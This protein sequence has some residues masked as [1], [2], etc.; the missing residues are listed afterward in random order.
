MVGIVGAAVLMMVWQ[1]RVARTA[2]VAAVAMLLVAPAIYSATVWQ[3]PVNGTFPV[4]GP[5][6]EDDVESLGIPLDQV[7]IYRQL[8]VYVRAHQPASRW[9]VLTQGATTAAPLT[10]LGGRVGALGGYGT[11]DPVLEPPALAQLVARGEIRYVALGGGY[12]TRGGNAS[13]TVVAAACTPVAPAKWRSPQNIGSPGHP[14]IV[15]P[16][17]GWNLQLY[18]C[19]GRSR[20]IVAA[21]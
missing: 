13:S 3:V 4:A 9:D 21:H 19:A 16:H 18:D 6:I 17:G 5:Y 1:P 8:L 7:P 20:E 14:S 11:I 12:A 15:Y 10:L 2:I